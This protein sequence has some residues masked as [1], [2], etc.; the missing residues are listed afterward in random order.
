VGEDHPLVEALRDKN[1]CFRALAAWALIGQTRTLNAVDA[2][3]E[4]LHDEDDWVRRNAARALGSCKDDRALPALLSAAK[5]DAAS[6][7]L[8]VIRS[9]GK[10]QTVPVGA[11][12]LALKDED[13]SIRAHAAF[14]LGKTGL[15]RSVEYVIAALKDED[16]TVRAQAARGLG[17]IPGPSSVDPLMTALKDSDKK[18]R[19]Q[20]SLSLQ[21]LGDARGL[22]GLAPYRPDI[23]VEPLQVSPYEPVFLTFRWENTGTMPREIW[24]PQGL[25][26]RCFRLVIDDEIYKPRSASDKIFR[27]VLHPG[28]RVEAVVNVLEYL[29]LSTARTYTINITLHCPSQVIAVDLES[30]KKVRIFPDT[31]PLMKT[32]QLEV[33]EPEIKACQEAFSVL[34]SFLAAQPDRSG[35]IDL[36]LRASNTILEKDAGPYR[37]A[38]LYYRRLTGWRLPGESFYGTNFSG[39]DLRQ[40]SHPF[41]KGRMLHSTAAFYGRQR[42]TGLAPRQAIHYAHKAMDPGVARPSDH[43]MIKL[44]R[45]L[46]VWE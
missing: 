2:L 39:R 33:V 45:S 22:K 31:P 4:A 15:D 10:M 6:V 37:D 20:A 38:A 19:E 9:L 11:L 42:D 29:D 30:G 28:Q 43:D 3:V 18:V 12:V 21:R 8:Q 32:F 41:W 17:M 36:F 34:Q 35:F 25:H 26:A 16:A 23:A 7:R 24:F 40:V 5:D 14:L 46:R 27:S 1:P 13:P 44:L